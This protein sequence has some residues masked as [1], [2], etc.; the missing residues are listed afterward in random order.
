[1]AKITSDTSVKVA[2]VSAE[3]FKS[4]LLI[5]GLF[6]ETKKLPKEYLAIDKSLGGVIAELIALG[7][8]SAKANET[9]LLYPK[10]KSKIDRVL[11]V[12]LGDKEKYGL[13]VLRC[14]S[15]T[16]AKIAEKIGV[17]KCSV[18]LHTVT[19]NKN[20]NISYAQAAQ[21]IAEGAITGRYAF[22]DYISQ[23]DSKD[24]KSP[25][26]LDMTIVESSAEI[27]SQLRSGC[28]VG[29]IIGESQNLTRMIANKPGNEINPSNL[30]NEAKSI[31]RALGLKCRVFD[32]KELKRLKMNAILAVGSGSANKPRLIILEH[33]GNKRK[34][35]PDI[36]VVG[37]AITFDS[38]G[39]CIKP[40]AGMEAMKFDKSG[41][42]AVLGIMAAVARL[43][44]KL[45]VIGLIP[46]AENMPSHT[47]YRPGDII[48]TYS[49]KTVEVQNT[50]AEGRMILSDA[51]NYVAKKK[52]KA[53]I[54]MA[55]LTGAC[56]IALGNHHAGLFSNN[57]ELADKLIESGKKSGE[58]V[59][60]LPCSEEYLEQMK[61]K[62]ADLRNI[63]GREG[64]P[65]TAAAF[66]G[67]F[68]EGCPW[69]HIDIAGMAD[70]NDEK[71]YRNV[72]ATGF[73]VRMVV[74]YL[75]EQANQA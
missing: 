4:E 56:V 42:C 8:F 50:D 18:M 17:T 1:M 67:E 71:P 10:S 15:G 7:D 53:I 61:S 21:A 74:E 34:N 57:D 66:L 75:R 60:R 63:G 12:G 36:A 48:K 11:V 45:N 5:I 22:R 9:I 30:A 68:V 73:P 3:E 14:A 33:K 43:K 16:A 27:A 59:W 72:G 65:C 38:G 24:K 47:S 62:I 29:V 23:K 2:N 55:T 20:K 64:G 28:A 44:L 6:A 37:K 13:D 52:P 49:G 31:A 19:E 35:A 69:A 40:S 46:S 39:I 26:K 51:L 54:D 58:R 25:S 70:T 32:E 41:G